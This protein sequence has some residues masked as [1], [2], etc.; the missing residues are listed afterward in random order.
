M[1]ILL[2]SRCTPY[3]L[4]FGDRLIVY[5]LARHLAAR[6]HQLDLLAFGDPAQDHAP[7]AGYFQHV[8][9]IPETPRGVRSLAAR[10]LLPG[11]RFPGSDA[12]CWSPPMWKAIRR[13]CLK[14]RYDVA[15]LFGGIHVYEFAQAVTPLPALITPYE[16]YTL[17]LRRVVAS[18]AHIPTWFRLQI[19]R[20]FERFMFTPY[21]KT[22]VVA[23]R[24]RDELLRLNPRLPVEVIANG[25]DLDYFAQPEGTPAER[26]PATFLFTGNFEYAPNV[27][28]AVRLA[29]RILPRV[30]ETLPDARLLLVGNK[31]PPE[32]CA[33]NGEFVT[34]TGR[35]PDIRPYL[36][37][38]TAFVSALRIGAGIKNKVLEALAMGCPVIAT[39]LSLDGIAA[40]DGHEALIAADDDAIAAAMLRLHA[41][42]DLRASLSANG[43]R[44]IE[45]HYSWGEAA[46]RYEQLYMEITG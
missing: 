22:V 31:P 41:D 10:L 7:F 26:K 9:V 11:Q 2:I 14:E 20:E 25:I 6:G 17:F 43:R 15:H 3:P 40:R 21:R 42:P 29:A 24:D 32:M 23:D 37:E 44:L 35:V 45:A 36:S 1:R 16:S 34:V 28:A 5:H 19:T 38:A 8:E 39:P 27:E 18:S 13:R 4:Y 33:L 12:A 46:R 30:R